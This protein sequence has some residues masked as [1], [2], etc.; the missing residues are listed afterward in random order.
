MLNWKYG[1]KVYST[2]S[3]II[4]ILI[5]FLYESLQSMQLNDPFESSPVLV[6]DRFAFHFIH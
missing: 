3:H 2:V 1:R 6:I 4:Q 5:F